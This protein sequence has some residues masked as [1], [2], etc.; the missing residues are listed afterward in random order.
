[1]NATE[2][3]IEAYFR[4]CR[5]CFTCSDRKVLGGNNRQLDLL[6]YNVKEKLPYHIEVSVTHQLAWC[7]SR[8]ELSVEFARKFFGVPP[9]RESKTG[10]KTDHEKGKS[11]FPEIE[12]AYKDVGFDPD[13]VKRVWVCWVVKGEENNK[14]LEV[15]YNFE[16]LNRQ[17]K[18]EILSL[19]DLILPELEKKIG[20]A[21]YDDEI[22][23]TLGLLKERNK[24]RPYQE[25]A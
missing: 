17:F 12:S 13:S 18:I 22:L 15:S 2:H 23:R 11:Y 20:T 19:R 3:I 9:R 1:M 14:P 8:Q 24:Q 7:Q 4:L 21:H 10:R 25:H 5:G 16:R 6:A